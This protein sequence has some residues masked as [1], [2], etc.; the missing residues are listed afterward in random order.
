MIGNRGLARNAVW[1]LLSLVAPMLVALG[2][3][4]ALIRTLGADRFGILTL[5]WMLIG[6]C[7]LFDLGLGRALTKLVSEGS[8]RGS[9]GQTAAQKSGQCGL[10]RSGIDVGSRVRGRADFRFR[11]RPAGDFGAQGSGRATSRDDRVPSLDCRRNPTG[12][13]NGGPAR[14]PRSAPAFRFPQYSPH[15]YRRVDLCRSA[16]CRPIFGELV[17]RHFHHCRDPAAVGGSA[18]HSLRGPGPG[19][20]SPTGMSACGKSARC[21]DSAVG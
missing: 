20:A 17:G 7:S 2:A 10:D 14:S 1:N 13:S 19:A 8:R 4:P 21:F 15:G 9:F 3:I 11:L 6:Y 5:A 12:H 18:L 16:H